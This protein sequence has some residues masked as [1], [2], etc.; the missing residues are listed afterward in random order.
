[1]RNPH[2]EATAVLRRLRPARA[3]ALDETWR[4]KPCVVVVGR[5]GVGKTTLINRWTNQSGRPVGLGGV[6]QSVEALEDANWTWIDTPGIDNP[7]RAL[8]TLGPVVD[9]ADALVWVVDG[10]QPATH[11][12]R[13]VLEELAEPGQGLLVIVSR[14]DLVPEEERE[15]VLA[16][17]RTHTPP[18][19]PVHGGDLRQWQTPPP[20]ELRAPSPRRLRVNEKAFQELLDT[21]E[22]APAMDQRGWQKRLTDKWH[23]QLHGATERA[24]VLL[25]RQELLGESAALVW[26]SDTHRKMSTAVASVCPPAMARPILPQ[27]RL[28]ADTAMDRVAAAMG[29][30][31]RARRRIRQAAGAWMLEGDMAIADWAAD[32]PV[33]NAAS[34]QHRAD[35]R[36][37]K[38]ALASL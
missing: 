19:T 36:V 23:E 2:P 18:G 37:L 28:D 1:M 15:A 12:A 9:R 35:C 29:G 21:L 33:L 8:S 3:D 5:I 14:L 30:P 17:I 13:M 25:E 4:A 27:L 34:A 32:H 20:D 24:L 11:T 22:G 6:T 26:L 38:T 7:D 31:D 10:L 16:R